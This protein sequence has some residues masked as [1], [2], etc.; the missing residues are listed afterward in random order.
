MMFR[1]MVSVLSV[2]TMVVGAGNVWSQDY[3]NR[4]IRILTGGAGG[5]NDFIA[6]TISQGMSSTLGQPVVIENRASQVIAG[7]GVAKAPPDGYTLGY[8]GIGLWITSILQKT[9]YDPV[10]DYT[11]ISL[12]TNSPIVLVVHP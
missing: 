2:A 3:P 10:R 4:P 6:R 8:F 5:G 9:S 1:D 11:P 12:V 7:E